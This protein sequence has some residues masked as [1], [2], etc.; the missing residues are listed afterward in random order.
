MPLTPSPNQ[1][2]C[3]WTQLNAPT[4]DGHGYFQNVRY[5]IFIKICPDLPSTENS[6]Y[7]AMLPSVEHC[8]CQF[9]VIAYTVYRRDASNYRQ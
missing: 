1:G 9:T 3:Q 2:H 4:P 8:Q 5:L 6:A 7:R